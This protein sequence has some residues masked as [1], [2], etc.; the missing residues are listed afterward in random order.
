MTDN[1]QLRKQLFDKQDLGE[2]ARDTQRAFDTIPRIL[3]K[4]LEAYYSEPM[5]LG[6]PITGEEPESIRLAR[7]TS[8]VTPEQPVLCGDMVHYVWKPQQ[9]GCVV[10]SIDGLSP[11]TTLKYRFVFDFKF[12]AKGT[13]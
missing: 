13:R 3:S 11:S 8:I 5:T 12:P 9:N 4:T 1:T 7:I 10:T 6:S 2:H